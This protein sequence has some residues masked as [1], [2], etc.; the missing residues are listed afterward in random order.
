ML[1]TSDGQL[2]LLALCDD[3]E[4]EFGVKLLCSNPSIG[5]VCALRC[6]HV[7]NPYCTPC[8]T[9]PRAEKPQVI[10]SAALK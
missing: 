2:V 8:P 1:L 9:H 4:S 6:R 10:W 3:P 7:T 5:Q